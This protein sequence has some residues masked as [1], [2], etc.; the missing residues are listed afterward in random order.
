MNML[1][2]NE[3]HRWLRNAIWAESQ[4]D[5]ARAEHY[6]NMAIRWEARI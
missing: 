5:H 1:A 4:G 6:L 3:M 2:H